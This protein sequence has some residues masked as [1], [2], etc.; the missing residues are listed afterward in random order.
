MRV[1]FY[2]EKPNGPGGGVEL[3]MRKIEVLCGELTNISIRFHV[4]HDRDYI[5][6]LGQPNN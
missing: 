3:G 2:I 5:I 6:L 1:V 4:G